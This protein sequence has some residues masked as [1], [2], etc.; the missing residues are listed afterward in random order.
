MCINAVDDYNS[1]ATRQRKRQLLPIAGNRLA[2]A[3]ACKSLS[4]Q[5]LQVPF[6]QQ[7]A[8]AKCGAHKGTMSQQGKS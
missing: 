2:D 1:D 8:S 5:E 4:S 7:M 3:E 6:I